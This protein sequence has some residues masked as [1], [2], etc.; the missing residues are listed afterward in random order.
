MLL[1]LMSGRSM[2]L[3]SEKCAIETY[4]T[5]YSAPKAIQCGKTCQAPSHHNPETQK[6]NLKEVIEVEVVVDDQRWSR[7]VENGPEDQPE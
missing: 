6:R 4:K 2:V 5:C 1:R 7:Q 3:V